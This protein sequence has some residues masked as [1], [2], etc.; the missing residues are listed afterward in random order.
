MTTHA[1]LLPSVDAGLASA[2]HIQRDCECGSCAS[3][4]ADEKLGIQTK[5]TIGAPG[6]AFEQEADRVADQIVSGNDLADAP[7]VTTPVI[8]RVEDTPDRDEEEEEETLQMLGAAGPVKARNATIA[9]TAV[10][11]GGQP[12]SRAERSFFEPR[13]GRDLS[14]VRLHTDAASGAAATGIN[15]RAYTLRNHIAFAE[16]QH[17][18]AT[19]EGRRLMAHELT[20]VLQQGAVSGIVQRQEAP[21]EEDR[22]EENDAP[23]RA[24]SFNF[25]RADPVP[26]GLRVVSWPQASLEAENITWSLRAGTARVASGGEIDEDGKITFAPEQQG[27]TIT[28]RAT[29]DQGNFEA[30]ITLSRVPETITF[31]FDENIAIPKTVGGVT[32]LD[33]DCNQ[34]DVVWTIGNGT[35]TVVAGTVIDNATGAITLSENQEGGTLTVTATNAGGSL[36]AE[37]RTGSVPTGID[38]TSVDTDLGSATTYGA[39]FQHTFTSAAG[40]SDVLENLIVGERFPDAP[41]PTASSHRFVGAAWPL[42][43]GAESF[44]LNTGQLKNDGTDAF[45]L[46]GAGQFTAPPATSTLAPGD[47]V[48][49]PKFSAPSRPGR[50]ASGVNVGN[51]IASH[52]N[53]T[54]RNA[55][56]AFLSLT[57]QLHFFNPRAASG[58]RW[59]H[60]TDVTHDRRLKQDGTD[61]KLTTTVNGVEHDETYE[62]PP[63]LSGL[64]ATPDTTPKSAD[65][66]SD[67][68]AAPPATTV[69]LSVTM[70]PDALP[71]GMSVNWRITS[72]N[73]L[74]CTI[75]PDTSDPSAA[76]L[77]IGRTAGTI[78]IEAATSAGGNADRVSV[79][80]T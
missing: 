46:D 60:F 80:I 77:T 51:H 58:A 14:Q 35:A 31:N 1:S 54:P 29:S 11:S 68:S 30:T 23:E 33:A 16:G 21:P 22:E 63:A 50:A 12:L 44:T 49:T 48:T 5:L 6:D 20:H 19:T 72:R 70:L 53:P 38:S 13:F 69:A 2:G 43:R 10:A 37:F 57:Q 27:G 34:P 7:V 75:T 61:I 18:A 28:V 55:L 66:P 41:N 71:T 17:N 56:P 64:A 42:G 59:T 45:V 78:E 52:S 67:G 73:A 26:V 4:E 62:G 32:G 79:R 39:A 15:A 36:D 40:S 3:C 25:N 47:N 76:E 65:P 74:G 8:Q 24:I 9:A